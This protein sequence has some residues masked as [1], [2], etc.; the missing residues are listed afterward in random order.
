MR[1]LGAF[2]PT[3]LVCGTV[4]ALLAA[5]SGQ[6]TED[7]G[8]VATSYEERYGEILAL[9]PRGDR[10]APVDRL[11][12]ARD[13]GRFT[14]E[15][16][17]LYLLTAV[18]GR[19]VGAVFQGRGTFAFAPP[20]KVEQ[21]R[22]AL[23][24]K[25][26]ELDVPF[27]EVVWLFA[28][29][30]LAELEHTLRF[31]AA[32]VSGAVRATVRSS[33]GH[34]GDEDSRSFDP[35][36]LSAF[37][38]AESSA[39]FYAHIKRDGGAPLM[40]MVN[41]FELEGVTLATRAPRTAWTHWPEVICRFPRQ[42][43]R[44]PLGDLSDRP[45]GAV[46]RD[47]RLEVTLA[48][49]FVGELT[50]TAAARL[51]IAA[52]SPVGPWVPFE[53]FSKLRVDSARWEDGTPATVFRGKDARQLWVR[54]D[55]RLDARETRA[56]RLYYGGDLIDRYGDFFFIESSIAWYPRP[57]EGR[58]YATF[59]ITYHSPSH[60]LIASVGERV[61]S[62]VAGRV[63]T[64]R[65]VSPAPIRNASFNLGLF[66]DYQ[67]REEGAPPVTVMISER[68]H[69]ALRGSGLPRQRRMKETV[70]T[71]IVQS[72]QFFQ[73]VYGPPPVTRLHAT[74]IPYLHG[75][76]FP[77]LINLSW[78]TFQA[79]DQHGE[80]E[81][82]RAHE[83]AHQWWALGVDFATYHDQ[84]LS[85]GFAS[86][87]GLWYLHAARRDSEKY[88]GILRRWRANILEKRDE[89]SPIW[90]GYR[91]SSSKDE[92]GYRVL[93]YQKGAWVLH[94]L[95]ILMLDLRTASDDRFTAM[96]QDFYNTHRGGRAATQDFQVIVERHAGIPMDWFFRQWVYGTGIPSYRVAYRT[97]QADDGQYRVTLRVEQEHVAD[98]FQ[99]YVPVTVDLGQNR[100]GR[101]RV[102]VR[103]PRSE[104]TLPPLPA[105]PRG[106]T[107]NELDGV[108]SEVRMV[109]W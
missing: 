103:G 82:F 83:V 40:F 49:T 3:L 61:D 34:L 54:L 72:L 106:L 36:L 24:L 13:V 93:I 41:P 109:G 9:Q 64:T 22:L 38:N 16:G 45:G 27:T 107:F 108:L 35:D 105:R 6:S 56:L 102:L 68:A 28:D 69:R 88:F 101:F 66:E 55:R 62:T 79:T 33:L 42:G 85:E 44:L 96:M 10:A 87:S 4:P 67:V 14:L 86:F 15:R 78:V 99:A 12:L 20:T 47:Y 23:F 76:A 48:Q 30:T 58:S 50:F 39:L 37:L 5:Q 94:M 46:I 75:E 57:L 52:A 60:L 97:E 25:T 29:S 63:L 70:A 1:L 73:R 51:E 8:A 53:L 89:P 81:V 74:E 59:D 80:D 95:R 84:W 17:T 77:G 71:D 2:V 26:R 90:L 92:L 7:A 104:L 98:D 18:G 31:G 91:A 19:T 100:Q 65:W 11:V 21:D 32:S 43:A